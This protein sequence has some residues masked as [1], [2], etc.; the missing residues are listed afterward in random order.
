MDTKKVNKT[1]S[2]Q[3]YER[4]FVNFQTRVLFTGQ[5]DCGENFAEGCRFAKTLKISITIA[6][7][8]FTT[9]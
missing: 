8:P 9:N 6:L 7:K 3:C 5:G 2:G 1:N 4:Y